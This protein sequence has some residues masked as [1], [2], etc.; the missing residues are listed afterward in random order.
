M[1]SNQSLCLWIQN[2]EQLQDFYVKSMNLYQARSS[3]SKQMC[4]QHPSYTE[5]DFS[6]Q[7]YALVTP[8]TF[9]TDAVEELLLS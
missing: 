7:S 4:L 2:I 3:L 6:I 9:L 8:V 1:N 5:T